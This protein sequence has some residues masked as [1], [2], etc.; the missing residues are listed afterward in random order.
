MADLKQLQDKLNSDPKALEDFLN[1]P[2]GTLANEGVILPKNAEENLKQ[3]AAD[4]KARVKQ[5]GSS[6]GVAEEGGVSINIS[7]PI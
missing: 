5:L 7:I 4:A 1:D 2:V 3:L 6:L